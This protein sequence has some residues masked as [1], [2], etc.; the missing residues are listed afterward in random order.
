MKTC[1]ICNV[2]KD[3]KD[4]YKNTRCKLGVLGCCKICS[5]NKKKS[6]MED[7]SYSQTVKIQRAASHL[8][9]KAKN[10]AVS[11][12]RY[13]AKREELLE[14]QKKYAR[15]NKESRKCYASGRLAE[16]RV[17]TRKYREANKDKIAEVTKLWR[18]NNRHKLTAYQTRREA[19]RILAIPLWASCEW[20]KLVEVEVYHL[21]RLR[22]QLLGVAHNVDHVIP[23]TSKLVCGLHC[24]ANF[25]I[26]TKFE[27]VSKGNRRWPDM[28]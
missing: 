8:E 5:E 4:F 18:K 23:L 1:N 17:T 7:E 10:N 21:A 26:L 9:N 6:R 20:E 22:T 3:L 14:K 27:N 11:T 15:D 12:A 28:P 24:A 16:T 19:A 13:I 2:S 25:Q